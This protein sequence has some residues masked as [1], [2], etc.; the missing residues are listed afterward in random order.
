MYTLYIQK[1]RRIFVYNNLVP[2]SVLNTVN[3]TLI[4]SACL[5]TQTDVITSVIHSTQIINAT[6]VSYSI[7]TITHALATTNTIN[8]TNPQPISSS[9][10]TTI[11]S[12]EV[13]SLEKTVT[14]STIV[15]ISATPKA[16]TVTKI[17]SVNSSPDQTLDQQPSETSSDGASL[18]W[19]S[20]FILF[21]LLTIAAVTVSVYLACLRKKKCK[22]E[23]DSKADVALVQTNSLCKSCH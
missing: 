8:V 11:T 1:S 3:T 15:T 4:S 20:L 10:T 7:S 19:M 18:A 9:C 6:S 14:M 13:L 22:H 23:V 12:T 17:V 21:L 5:T 16:I 2:V